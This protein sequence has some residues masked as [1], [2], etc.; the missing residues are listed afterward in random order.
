MQMAS[1]YQPLKVC[2]R[3]VGGRLPSPL[4]CSIDAFARLFIPTD[5][6][7]HSFIF[8]N[9]GLLHY[10]GIII[11]QSNE[12][13]H[14]KQTYHKL[15][16]QLFGMYLTEAIPPPRRSRRDDHQRD[17]LHRYFIRRGEQIEDVAASS[18]AVAVPAA[19]P[20]PPPPSQLLPLRRRMFSF[21]LHSSN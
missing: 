2:R 19:A 18:L 21:F 5:L 16:T 7:H 9:K 17:G 20:P 3:R 13:A 4:D 14:N 6:F 10:N 1:S 11:G 8:R 12:K 15:I